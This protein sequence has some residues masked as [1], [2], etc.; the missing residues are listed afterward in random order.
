MPTATAPVLI[1]EDDDLVRET[2]ELVL[3]QEGFE[4]ATVRD[5]A[6]A[7]AWLH[8][9]DHRPCLILLDLMMPAM[10]GW[11]FRKEQQADPLIA[12]IPVVALSAA[13]YRSAKEAGLEV[14]A[15][16]R[17]PI[18]IDTLVGTVERCAA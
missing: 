12:H 6:E 4:V 11:A 1:I 17:K 15:M 3:R 14:D 8:D 13:G 7:L 9:R 5:G 18:D 16:L 2:L 10:D